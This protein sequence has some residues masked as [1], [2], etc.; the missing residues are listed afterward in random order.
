MI[1]HHQNKISAPIVA[2]AD[3]KRYESLAGFDARS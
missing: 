3:T 1:N 2:A